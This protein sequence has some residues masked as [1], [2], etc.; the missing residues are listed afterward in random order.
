[1]KKSIF[2]LLLKKKL[3]L[4]NRIAKLDNIMRKLFIVCFVLFS[5]LIA[6][7]QVMTERSDYYVGSIAMGEI[8]L[9]ARVEVEDD[10]TTKWC[11]FKC[12]ENNT[13]LTAAIKESELI[14]LI[15][16][17]EYLKV[18]GFNSSCDYF[19]KYYTIHLNNNGEIKVGF[20]IKDGYDI[21][22]YLSINIDGISEI[23]YP[24]YEKLHKI[25]LKAKDKLQSL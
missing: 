23:T 12:Y 21:Q 14:D 16:K 24:S 2:L 5:A 3:Y 25:L 13:N 18:N 8:S 10:I 22:W 4:C 1:M 11:V 20:Y 19:N 7:C 15:E 9:T 6:Q 17:V